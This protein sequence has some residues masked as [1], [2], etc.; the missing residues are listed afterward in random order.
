MA[1][2]RND[3]LISRDGGFP[4]MAFQRTRS[5]SV[6][7]FDRPAISAAS[8]SWPMAGARRIMI[9]LSGLPD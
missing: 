6:S 5:S 9:V 7:N 4:N 3:R 8:A 2:V 1:R